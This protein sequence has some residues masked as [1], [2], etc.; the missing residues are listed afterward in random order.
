MLRFSL[1]LFTLFLLGI[2][3]S[4]SAS[5]QP[6]PPASSLPPAAKQANTGAS[7]KSAGITAPRAHY[8]LTPEKR[9]KAI[10]FSRAEYRLYFAAIGLALA[11]HAFLWWSGF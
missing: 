10:A 9:A 4:V 8:V 7:Q 11:L 5:Q 3:P 6:T 2:P 1:L